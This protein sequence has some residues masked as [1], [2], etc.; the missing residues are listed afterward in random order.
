MKVLFWNTCQNPNIN[1]VLSELIAE[2]NISL[3]VLA[4]Y[5]GEIHELLKSV[6]EIGINMQKYPTI[7]CDR[8][9]IVGTELNISPGR[10]TDY[11]SFQIINDKDIFCCIHLPSQIFGSSEG[12]REIAIQH[13]VTD[14]ESTEKEIGTENSIILGDFNANPYDDEC[15]KANQFHA[16]PYY[17]ETLKGTR[18][19]AGEE[20]KMFYNPM[21]KFLGNSKEPFGTYYYSGN[22]LKNAFWNIYDQVVI[23]PSLKARFID[24]NLQILTKSQSYC[25]LN[26]QGYPEK[27]KISDH[28]P[29]I[30]EI[31][32]D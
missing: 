10:Q 4:E 17:K 8:I 20:F 32:E 26:K 12:M 2:N 23:R 16:I 29:I 30:F 21:W 15:L 18:T 27:K 14:I 19:I 7:G 13:I 25:L 5:A 1:R 28:L 6:G 22:D 9:K 11:A 31:L 24:S 3:V